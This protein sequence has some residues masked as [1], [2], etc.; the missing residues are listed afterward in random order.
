MYDGLSVFVICQ[1]A[2]TV[3]ESEAAGQAVK[4]S[5]ERKTELES[6]LTLCGLSLRGKYGCK[7]SCF[8]FLALSS[9][10]RQKCSRTTIR[11]LF[12]SSASLFCLLSF[13]PSAKGQTRGHQVLFWIWTFICCLNAVL[14]SLWVLLFWKVSLGQGSPCYCCYTFNRW[15]MLAVLNLCIVISN[16]SLMAHFYLVFIHLCTCMNRM[17]LTCRSLEKRRFESQTF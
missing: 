8:L 14:F 2:Y 15:C 1:F 16:D 12:S 7:Y 17:N 11:F 13:N 4:K 3:T 10:I 5:N 9:T 6:S